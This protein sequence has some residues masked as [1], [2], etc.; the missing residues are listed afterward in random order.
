M[1]NKCGFIIYQY[2][3]Y[4]NCIT[5]SDYQGMAQHIGTGERVYFID[6]LMYYHDTCNDALIK[7]DVSATD[8]LKLPGF[9][10]L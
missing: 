8:F 7:L 2:D 1:E 5:I 3:T 10:S 4:G 6:G 9:N